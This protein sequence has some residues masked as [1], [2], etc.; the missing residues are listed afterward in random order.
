MD[1][2]Y[3]QLN[4][5]VSFSKGLGESRTER[6]LKVKDEENQ[7]RDSR[8][9]PIPL[10]QHKKA[11][12]VLSIVLPVSVLWGCRGTGLIREKRGW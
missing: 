5:W 12:I 2:E 3:N 8:K 11:L 9:V 10:G 7:R 4:W 6:A 1:C